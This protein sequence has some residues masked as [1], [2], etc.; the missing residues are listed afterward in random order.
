MRGSSAASKVRLTGA[1]ALT[2]LCLLAATAASAQAATNTLFA[3]PA[4]A[5]AGDCSSAA[6]ACTIDTAV[7]GANATPITDSVVIELAS[8]NYPLGAPSPTALAV[9]F[10]GP[11]LTIEAA[12]GTPVLSGTDTVRVLSVA[13]ASTV[14]V[15]GVTFT[16]GKTSANG[17]AIENAGT[18]TA[19]CASSQLPVKVA[20]T[21][22]LWL[23]ARSCRR[24]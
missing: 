12:S 5:G 14:T 17:G 8:G 16:S 11:S 10:A 23:W 3:A 13:A 7:N 2:S 6:N 18:S 9:T 1:A 19:R 15:D 24:P 22:P 4:A 20:N 21:R